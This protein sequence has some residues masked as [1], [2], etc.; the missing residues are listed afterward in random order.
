LKIVF[1]SS[2]II[3]STSA[4]SINVM[5]MCSSFSKLGHETILFAR[6]SSFSASCD[7]SYYGIKPNFTIFK[8][9]WP[10]FRGIGGIIYGKLNQRIFTTLCMPDLLY[11]RDLYSL[12]FL[13][14]RKI[15]I[16]YESHK[17]PLNRFHKKMEKYLFKVPNF[18]K[19]V[20]I[21]SALKSIYIDMFPWLPENKIAVAHDSADDPLTYNIN[22][23]KLPGRDNSIKVGY[24]GSFYKGR[25]IENIIKLAKETT[26]V[27]YHLIGGTKTQVQKYRS[28]A[29][30]L[31]NL[32][33]HG[34]IPHGNLADYFKAFDILLAPYQKKVS[35]SDKDKSSDTSIWM[36]PL[37]IFEYMAWG[38]AIIASNIPVLKEILSHKENCIL[39][40]P[41]NISSWI[42][43]VNMLSTN[44]I[45][46]DSIGLRAKQQFLKHH[47]WEHRAD[48]VL[49]SI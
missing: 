36:S 5:K 3:P 1:F 44:A 35:V 14:N 30:D 8:N 15:P 11:G 19:L 21:S 9:S 27:D 29:A 37:K 16:I 48:F 17:P 10:P 4:N 31:T 47:T 6:N 23:K 49:K 33:F 43:A 26:Q 25:G 38:K 12:F 20:V 45:L 28:M 46:R 18:R 41:E 42:D 34:F 22:P 32:F 24:I 13:R 7:F 39:C 2:S 40:S